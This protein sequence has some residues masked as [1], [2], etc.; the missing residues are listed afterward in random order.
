MNC[1]CINQNWNCPNCGEPITAP[2]GTSC[3]NAAVHGHDP[4]CRLLEPDYPTWEERVADAGY[5]LDNPKR[6][7]V[8]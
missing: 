5:S 6:F 1:T 2:A 4:A 8:D 7:S 3:P